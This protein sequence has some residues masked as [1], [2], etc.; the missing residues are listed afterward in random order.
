MT[1]AHLSGAAVASLPPQRFAVGSAISQTARIKDLDG[2]PHYYPYDANPGR[3]AYLWR[4]ARYS[5]REPEMD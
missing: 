4:V 2:G 1:F 3:V 5:D